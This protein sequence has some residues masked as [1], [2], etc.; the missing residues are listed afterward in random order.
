M[1]VYGADGK[2]Y[3]YDRYAFEQGLIEGFTNSAGSPPES[4]VCPDTIDAVVGATFTCTLSYQGVEHV[5]DA[6]FTDAT[7]TMSIAVDGVVQP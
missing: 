2:P 1:V 5:M 3:P 4:L 6:T 7:G